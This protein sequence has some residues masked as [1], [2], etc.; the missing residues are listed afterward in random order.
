MQWEVNGLWF[1]LVVHTDG[2]TRCGLGGYGPRGRG[3]AGRIFTADPEQTK[4]E[5]ERCEWLHIG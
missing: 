4:D 5:Q 1:F 2:I 3:V